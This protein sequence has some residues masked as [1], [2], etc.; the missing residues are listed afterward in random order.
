MNWPFLRLRRTAALLRSAR[1][2]FAV[3]EQLVTRAVASLESAPVPQTRRSYRRVAAAVGATVVVLFALGFVPVPRSGGKGALARAMA[4][5]ESAPSVFVHYRWIEPAQGGAVSDILQWRTAEGLRR[6]EFHEAGQLVTLEVY[7]RDSFLRYDRRTGS[8]TVGEWRRPAEMT[9]LSV[10]RLDRTF[11]SL[12]ATDEA[13]RRGSTV[14][15]FREGSLW[16]GTRDVIEV[17]NRGAVQGFPGDRRKLRCE[18]DPATGRLLS[19]QRYNGDGYSWTL[20]SWTEEINWDGDIP[21]ETWTFEPPA[22]TKVLVENNWWSQHPGGPLATGRSG[23]WELTLYSMDRDRTGSLYLA[24]GWRHLTG[25]LPKTDPPG[26]YH[27]GGAPCATVTDDA[28]GV[29]DYHLHQA[30]EP[31]LSRGIGGGIELLKLEPQA[32]AP[33]NRDARTVTVTLHTCNYGEGWDYEVTFPNLPLPPAR[34]DDLWT[35]QEIQY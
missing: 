24:V 29:Y 7:G 6:D 3:P 23:G 16:G 12:Q 31:P 11:R 35:V 30:H 14:R 8:A 27:Y 5:M 17:E 34:Q 1:T 2:E 13:T 15:E 21:E 28:G 19:E 18:F 33:P 25:P 10:P 20:W 22:G 9:P 26:Y 4:A 32:E